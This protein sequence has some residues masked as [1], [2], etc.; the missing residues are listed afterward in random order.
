MARPKS[1]LPPDQFTLTEAAVIGA[2]FPP[3]APSLVQSKH[4][5]LA[6]TSVDRGFGHNGAAFYDSFGVSHWAL[7]G[8]L[9]S[10]GVPLLAAC[11]LGSLIAD[12][13]GAAYGRL[14]SR[15][16]NYLEKA[17]N[18]KH[19]YFPWPESPL[20]Q[21]LSGAT[22]D[23]WQHHLL[24]TQTEIYQPGKLLRG[25]Y[26]IEIVNREYVFTG[27]DWQGKL[28]TMSPFGGQA[29]D[30]SP[31][32][33]IQGWSRGSENLEIRSII[34]ELPGGWA[35]NDPRAL[36]GARAI[37]NEF[38]AA[39]ANAA[40]ALRINIS[41]AIRNALDAI[42]DHRVGRG[43]KFDWTASVTNSVGKAFGCDA[44]GYPLDPQHPWNAEG[45]ATAARNK[46][47]RE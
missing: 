18:P 23:F 29:S 39:R 41:L 4:R 6:P 36:A 16:D 44:D 40:S 13:L 8:A 19:P 12:E 38:H 14:P 42:H 17:L 35:D 34:E 11:R 20:Q 32:Y 37:E 22:S 28:L 1:N 31:D 25:D 30:L 3:R 33:R 7:N 15:L 24:R 21:Y 47:N 10:S 26:C 2:G 27:F 5:H 45:N 9:Y 46:R 43:A